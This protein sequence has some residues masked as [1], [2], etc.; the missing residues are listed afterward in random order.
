MI[1]EQVLLQVI[2]YQRVINSNKEFL[3]EREELRN[4]TIP[5]SFALIISG[6]RRC[7]KSTLLLL[8]QKTQ[9][10]N[11]VL[12]INFDNSKLYNFELSDFQILD[13]I[14]SSTNKKTLFFDEIQVIEGWEIYVRQKLDENYKV[15]VTGSNA[16]LLSKE[17]GTKLTG[18]HLSKELFP[19]SYTEFLRQSNLL[20]DHKSTEIY[21]QKGGFP[22]YLRTNQTEILTTLF[23]DII[24]RDIA[25]RYNVRDVHSLK[26]LALILITNT[27]NLISASKLKQNLSIKSTSTVLEYFSYFE[28]SYLFFFVPIFS[29]SIKN[30]LVN[31]RKVYSID[32]GLIDTISTSFTKNWGHILENA[33]Y[34]HLR[35]S[36]K[37]I[38]YFK[39]KNVECDFVVVDRGNVVS[40]IQVCYEMNL[41]NKAREM[42]GL[43]EAMV[44]LKL[45]KGLI[46]T[47][48]QSDSYIYKDKFVE[49]I[50]AHQ[51]LSSP[52]I[53]S[54]NI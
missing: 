52:P 31:P 43:N 39:M 23:D 6:I 42:N 46:I 29:Y 21:L 50:T 19:Y 24:Y 10:E 16:S 28:N 37:E 27:G 48:N 14:I 49:I 7:G 25:V 1:Q 44:E 22:E 33:V 11:E 4:I 12:Y 53:F 32:L 5:S 2:D 9:I 38:Y 13:K 40:L 35:R 8:L 36:Y 17:L 20:A 45:N 15:V 3:L 34:L 26:K 30:Q 54:P 18:R 41:E 47:L 51:F